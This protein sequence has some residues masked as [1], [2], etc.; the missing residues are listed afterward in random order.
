M[1][2]RTL[3]P[4]TAFAV[5]L[6]AASP[7]SATYSIKKGTM[8][9]D[10]YL[11]VAIATAGGGSGAG[12]K[13]GS[14]FNYSLSDVLAYTP[15]F[16][17]GFA[18]GVV[19]LELAPGGIKFR[20]KSLYKHNVNLGI[21]AQLALNFGF[22][23]GGSTIISVGPKFGPAFYYMFTDSIGAGM[24]FNIMLGGAFGGGGSAF[25]AIFDIVFGVSVVF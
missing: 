14:D 3:I 22:V 4:V 21:K 7:A 24:V 6:S 11:G 25:V 9:L 19:N 10:M 13:L 20:I 8:D 18:S 12:F 23:S 2:K 17:L 15:T 1:K 16:S 5:A